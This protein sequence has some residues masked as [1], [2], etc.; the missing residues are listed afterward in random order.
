VSGLGQRFWAEAASTVV[1]QINKT[2]SSAIDFQIREEKWT[3][4][5]PDLSG[6]RRFGC[7]VFIHSDKGKLNPRAKKRYLHRL[8]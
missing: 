8:S 4:G 2:P 5:T 1:Y 7:L 6:L 3:S